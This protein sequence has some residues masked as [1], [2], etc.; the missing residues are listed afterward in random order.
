[1]ILE[2]CCYD[3]FELTALEMARQGVFG[4]I[5]HAEGA[6]NHNLDPFWKAYWN[7]WRLDFNRQHR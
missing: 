3:F 4:E 2:N 1:M 6:Y 5:I 7:N